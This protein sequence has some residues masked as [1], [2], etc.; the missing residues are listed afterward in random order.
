MKTVKSLWRNHEGSALIEAALL[1][2]MLFIMV[3]GIFEFS[4]YFYQQQLIE[5]GIRDAVRYLAR[6]PLN[7]GGGATPCTQTDAGG[8]S[9]TTYAQNIAIYGTA[10]AGTQRVKGWAG[11]VTITCPTTDDS[12]GTYANTPST[13][14]IYTITATTS[15]TDPTLGYFDLLNLKAPSISVTHKERFIGPG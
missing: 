2:P 4:F 3:F 10:S 5:A 9:Y 13:A 7:S 11:P 6:I 15:F 14:P 12:A 8:T 1:T